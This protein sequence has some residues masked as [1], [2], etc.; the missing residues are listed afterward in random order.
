MIDVQQIVGEQ[1]A[2]YACACDVCTGRCIR[3]QS[4]QSIVPHHN[5]PIT[6]RAKSTNGSILAR[7]LAI[8]PDFPNELSG[9]VKD[10][11]NWPLSIRDDRTSFLADRNAIHAPKHVVVVAIKDTDAMVHKLRPPHHCPEDRDTTILR[12]TH[13]PKRLL[14]TTHR[15]GFYH[16]PPAARALFLSL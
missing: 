12:T 5:L 10:S 6:K 2:R 7:S 13:V 15:F 11:N 9:C 4:L 1:S 8:P 3:I 14:H 16:N